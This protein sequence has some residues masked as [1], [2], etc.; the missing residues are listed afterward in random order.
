MDVQE[1]YK[2]PFQQYIFSSQ[3]WTTYMFIVFYVGLEQSK[4]LYAFL[5]VF[6]RIF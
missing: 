4:C 3:Y 5:I 1:V 2:L 6:E